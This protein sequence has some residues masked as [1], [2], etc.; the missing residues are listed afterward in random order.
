MKQETPATSAESKPSILPSTTPSRFRTS[1]KAKESPISEVSNGALPGLKARPRSVPPDPN[2]SQKVRRPLVLNKPKSAEDVV[3]SQKGREVEDVK[4]VGRFGNRAVVEQFARPRRRVD[5]VCK[6]NED[7]PDG[8]KKELQEKLEASENLVKDLQ[9]EVSA[10]KSQLEKVQSFKM[11]LELQNRQ[12]SEDLATANAK[13]SALSSRDQESVAEEFQSPKFKEVQK[14]IANKLENFGVKKEPINEV[15]TIKTQLAAP[16]HPFTKATD[17]HKKVPAFS[18][19]LPLPP[20]PPPPPPT[21]RAPA[22]AATTQKAPALLEFYH[23]LTKQERK[24]DNH[25]KPVVINAHSSIVGEI[26]NR[27]SHLLAVS[28]SDVE[29]KGEFIEVLIQKVQAAAYSN[30]DDVLKFMDWLDGELSS[31]ADERAVLKNFS[32]P[33]RKADALR[34]AAI[35]YRDLKRLEN[36]VS[37]FKD[38][39]SMPCGAALKKMASLLDKYI[40]QASMKLAKMYMKRVSMELESVRNSER[41]STQEALLLQGVRFAY[42]AHQLICYLLMQFAG[43]LDSE[44]MCAFEEIRQRVPVHMEGLE[45]CWLA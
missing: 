4:F 28:I 9:S 20:P 42:R 1:S 29:T 8:K 14:L 17:I 19:S 32:W 40:K 45:N 33:E 30:I 22:R 3:G 36:E 27:S 39:T 43:G 7:D 44:T 13:I 35:E 24:K 37:S 11:E 25:S 31:L 6:R 34:E 23:S 12:F 5:P 21:R 38:D 41:E 16:L 10:L 18:S 26:Q 2:S 15:S